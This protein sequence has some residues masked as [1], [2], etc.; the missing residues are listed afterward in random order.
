MWKIHTSDVG[1]TVN[2]WV[3]ENIEV[4]SLDRGEG[5]K[6]EN[7]WRNPYLQERMGFI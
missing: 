2:V 1:T 6:G 7:D 3:K 5:S 4:A